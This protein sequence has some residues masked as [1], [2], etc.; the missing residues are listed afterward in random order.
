MTEQEKVFLQE[1]IKQ[2]DVVVETALRTADQDD[3]RSLRKYM[4]SLQATS[5]ADG[6]VMGVMGGMGGMGGSF[7]G[8]MGSMGSR[9]MGGMGMSV[10]SV[11]SLGGSMGGGLGG[12]MGMPTGMHL[13]SPGMTPSG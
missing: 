12:S 4:A 9:G 1:L 3:A 5:P 13:P 6:A 7:G 8:S 2:K 11:G 10:G